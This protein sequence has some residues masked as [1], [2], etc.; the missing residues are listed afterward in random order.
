[1]AE[2][3]DNTGSAKYTRG[4]V[5]KHIASLSAT[6]GIGLFAI[7]VVDLV[8]MY[9]I[10]LLGEPELA[11]A[12]GFAGIGL[13]LGA[14]VC[15]GVSIAISTRVAEALGAQ[16]SESA[17]RFAT[18][19]LLYSLIWT[20]P[21]TMAT[22]Y[23][24]S[25]LMSL[26][27][28]RDQT[29]ALSVS[30]FSIVGASLPLL[31]LA[32]VATSILRAAG[33]ANLSMWATI[34]GGVV[35]AIFDP[36]FIFVLAL[37]LDGA[38]IAS[39]LSRI[40]V[41]GVALGS[42]IRKHQL[43]CGIRPASLL[44]DFRSFSHVAIPSLLT[45]LSAPVGSAY[46]TA[47]MAQYGTDAVA[48][49]SVIG[50][51]TPVAFV[52]L[53]GLSTA[54]GPIA[55]Q[56]IGAKNY[57]RVFETLTAGII[58]TVLYMLPVLVLLFVLRQPL[59]TVFHLGED[60]TGILYFFCQIIAVAYVFYGIQLAANP[61]L[62]ALDHPMLSTMNNFIRDVALTI[63]MIA[64]LSGAMGA[65]GVLAGQAAGFVLAGIVSLLLAWWVTNQA[66]QG[67]LIGLFRYK[68]LVHHYR[69]VAPGVQQRGH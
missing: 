10:S 25:E 24:S 11:A 63:P 48:A 40:A 2:D 35:N 65:R 13:F 17:A 20:V 19:G 47:K 67:N 58:F 32:I 15:I 37:D 41:A 4:S 31:G 1:M 6:A 27:G 44:P 51:I 64:L 33:N 45:N 18:H 53:Y 22:L 54:V 3:S 5:F 61:I 59:A 43:L 30:Y 46:A 28:A 42:I 50:R 8:D 52:G 16:D 62:V 36:I 39:V 26:I 68:N 49:A 21:V 69:A 60:A 23:F 55:S 7:F 9:F 56:N 12:I 14:S 29:L 57:Q 34:I 38:A 66:R